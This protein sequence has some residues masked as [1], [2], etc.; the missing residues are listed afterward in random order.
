MPETCAENVLIDPLADSFQR[1][2][3]FVYPTPIGQHPEDRHDKNTG[4]QACRGRSRRVSK[5]ATVLSSIGWRHRES[6]NGALA[7]VVADL[8]TM[9]LC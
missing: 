5:I 7:D 9:L 8:K 6:S 2:R 1:V 4:R 3:T